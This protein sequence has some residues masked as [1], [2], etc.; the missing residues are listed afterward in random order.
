MS[1]SFTKTKNQQQEHPKVQFEQ[2]LNNIDEPEDMLTQDSPLDLEYKLVED[3]HWM[4]RS[5]RRNAQRL[6]NRYG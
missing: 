3:S 5:L 1:H 6:R 2:Y 4:R